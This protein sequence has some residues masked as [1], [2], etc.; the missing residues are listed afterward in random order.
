MVRNLL[1]AH[2]RGA[3]QGRHAGIIRN[4]GISAR[5]QEEPNHFDC[6]KMIAMADR[7]KDWGLTIGTAEV[8]I[9]FVAKQGFE[10]FCMSSIRCGPKGGRAV[11]TYYI[12]AHSLALK[13][14]RQEWNGSITTLTPRRV[15]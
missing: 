11:I 12:E 13:L 15:M 7:N 4:V 10:V 8:Q 1:G 3:H 9:Y 14:A 2:L 6:S 5:S